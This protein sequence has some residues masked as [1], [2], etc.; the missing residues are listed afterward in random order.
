M[1]VGL[2]LSF[3]AGVSQSDAKYV[4]AYPRSLT[5]IPKMNFAAASVQFRYRLLRTAFLY[6]TLILPGVR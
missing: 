5:C 2:Y 4:C 6:S 3:R 1:L